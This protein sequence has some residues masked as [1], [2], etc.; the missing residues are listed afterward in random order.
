MNLSGNNKNKIT[1]KKCQPVMSVTGIND[2]GHKYYFGV[3][4]TLRNHSKIKFY[5]K[6]PSK[7]FNVL[8]KFSTMSS[9]CY[10]SRLI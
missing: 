5:M 3:D 1:G 2:Q 9:I 4:I 7:K 10:L 6:N 8:F